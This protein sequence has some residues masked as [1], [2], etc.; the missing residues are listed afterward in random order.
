MF[1]FGHLI[2]LFWGF[3]AHI[4]TARSHVKSWSHVTRALARGQAL[5]TAE[6][7]AR[8]WRSVVPKGGLLH[9]ACSALPEPGLIVDDLDLFALEQFGAGGL[10]HRGVAPFLEMNEHL[11][12][13]LVALVGLGNHVNS[14]HCAE[15]QSFN[16]R[17]QIFAGRALE[18]AR[19]ADAGL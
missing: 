10:S 19:N 7:N 15:I 3:F 1:F 9:S 2:G 16:H 8:R 6:I 12:V 11:V 14:L 4:H 13:G 18:H 5:A 17:E